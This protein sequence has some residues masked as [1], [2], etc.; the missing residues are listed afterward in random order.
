MSKQWKGRSPLGS[1]LKTLS[2]PPRALDHAGLQAVRLPRFTGKEGAPHRRLP[3]ARAPLSN[4]LSF[5][6]QKMR[7]GHYPQLRRP[8]GAAVDSG[9]RLSCETVPGSNPGVGPFSLYLCMSTA[10]KGGYLSEVFRTLVQNGAVIRTRYILT[11][12]IK[13]LT[14]VFERRAREVWVGNFFWEIFRD[15]LQACVQQALPVC[16]GILDNKRKSIG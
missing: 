13:Q 11:A 1:V 2:P 6:P 12:A 15:T 16:V 10:Q 7:H 14:W 8:L 4:G 3:Q 5:M 9:F